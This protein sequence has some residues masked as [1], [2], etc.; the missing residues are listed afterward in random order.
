MGASKFYFMRKCIIFL[1]FIVI[2]SSTAHSS[3]GAS[4]ASL[5]FSNMLRGGYAER[6]IVVSNPTDHNIVAN[7]GGEG[8]IA[9][10]ISIEPSST[11]IEPGSNSK[12]VVKVNP[13][14]DTPNGI[15]RGYV[16]VI[17]KPYAAEEGQMSVVGGV[18]LTVTVEI[19]DEE[20][21]QYEVR[22][23]NVPA[24]EEC[25]PIETHITVVNTGN[26][27]VS[28]DFVLNLK[29]GE[30]TLKEKNY[31][32]EPMLPTRE[33]KF[34]VEMPYELEQYKCVP[35]GTYDID[36][37]AFLDGDKVYHKTAPLIIS[38]RGSLSILGELTNVK[39]PESLRVGQLT[40][41]EADFENRGDLTYRAQL[42]GEIYSGESLSQVVKGDVVDVIQG[43]KKTLSVLYR[44]L[45]PGKY[46]LRL[47]ALDTISGAK[48][49]EL[50][51]PFSVTIPVHI[52]AGIVLVLLII[53]LIVKRMIRGGR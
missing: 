30:K 43:E 52:A 35:V 23:F 14:E 38:E 2:F 50:E 44:P 7:A 19:T 46:T 11:V 49:S 33:Y 28:G 29:S 21:K 1:I 27:R 39:I 51:Y 31:T 20:A 34:V 40:K 6:T 10:W 15:Y 22:R 45:F 25:R 17:G 9:E 8:E 16:L 36:F 26:V 47:Y 5:K 53:I 32:T 13:P 4:P 42:V 48:T 12:I 18:S 37:T 41:I 24:T 3:I